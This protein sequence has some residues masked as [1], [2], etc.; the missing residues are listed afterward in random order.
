LAAARAGAR[1]ARSGATAARRR[2]AVLLSWR[3]RQRPGR[4]GDGVRAQVEGASAARHREAAGQRGSEG[5]AAA[6]RGSE[7]TR[8]QVPARAR[9]AGREVSGGEREERE[10]EW[11]EER[12]CQRFDSV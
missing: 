12:K 3:E 6:Q 5:A 11:R 10:R 8:A 9:R 1:P 2:V 7:R 4:G